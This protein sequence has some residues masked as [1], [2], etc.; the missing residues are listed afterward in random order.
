MSQ[1]FRKRVISAVSLMPLSETRWRQAG[2]IAA[3]GI[4][5]VSDMIERLTDDHANA[6]ALA[7]GLA[8]IDGIAIDPKSVETNLVFFELT[9][10]DMTP[11]QLVNGLATQGI[12]LTASGGRRLRAVLNHHVTAAD[13]DQVL[14]AFRNTLASDPVTDGQKVVAYG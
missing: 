13:I 12:K 3:A 6:Q 8:A 7:Q 14:T 4:V 2:I 1:H 9:H 11:A 10:E 5:A